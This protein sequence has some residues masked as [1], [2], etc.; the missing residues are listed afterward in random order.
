MEKIAFLTVIY[1]NMRPI[2]MNIWSQ[3]GMLGSV[4]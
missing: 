3:E 4:D 2:E 1:E